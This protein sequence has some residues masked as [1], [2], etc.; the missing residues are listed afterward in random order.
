MA[1]NPG[2]IKQYIEGINF[3]IAKEDLVN[4]VRDR[5]APDAIVGFVQKLPMDEIQSPGDIFK[6]INPFS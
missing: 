3:P 2:E 6:A 1:I 4:Q 5:G